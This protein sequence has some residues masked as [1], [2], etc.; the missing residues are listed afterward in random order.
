MSEIE[1]F[2]DAIEGSRAPSVKRGGQMHCD[3]CDAVLEPYDKFGLYCSDWEILDRV[4]DEAFVGLQRAYCEDCRIQ[5]PRLPLKGTIELM[6]FGVLDEGMRT[7][8]PELVSASAPS[9]GVDWDPKELFEWLMLFPAEKA[10]EAM[11]GL[12]IGPEDAIGLLHNHG[13]EIEQVFDDDFNLI[14]NERTRTLREESSEETLETPTKEKREELNE[15][16]ERIR[17]E[18]DQQ[19]ER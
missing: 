1:K 14:D 8:K 17:E 7:R 12:H 15:R 3:E 19:W 5:V 9:K 16:I 11:G 13:M 6:L 10:V 4:G 18:H 2:L